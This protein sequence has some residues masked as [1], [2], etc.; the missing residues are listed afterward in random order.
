LLALGVVVPVSGIVVGASSALR[1]LF[2]QLRAA[3]EG[4]GSVTNALLD[5]STREAHTTLRDVA[6]L[7]SQH[8]ANAWRAITAVSR[9]S[10]TV[11]IDLL[12]FVGALYTFVVDGERAYAWM[13]QHAPIAREDLARFAR[14]F[15]ETGRGLIIAGG[16]TAL[17]QGTL[18]T[19]AY[20]AAGIPSAMVLGVLTAVCALVPFVGTGLVWIPLAIGLAVRAHYGQTAVVVVV[21][22]GVHNLVDNV[23]RP[24]LARHGRLQLPT[25]VVLVA[26]L[27]GIAV[28]GASG[29]LLGP[30]LVRLCVEALAIESERRLVA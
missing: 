25:F 26:M 27:G 3:L 7:A 20:V 23:V 30:L 21:G 13:E 24:Y 29:A 1:G 18:A 12:V 15:Q 16:G 6:N 5:E 8:G 22:A 17:A 4:R 19:I 28:F 9:A 10:A 11:A 2:D 14:A